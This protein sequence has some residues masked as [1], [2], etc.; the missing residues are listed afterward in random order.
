[1]QQIER[2]R[3]PRFKVRNPERYT[4]ALI[5]RQEIADVLGGYLLSAIRSGQQEDYDLII[6]IAYSFGLE[7][8]G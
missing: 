5:Q 8:D 7:A 2:R 6:S 4:S 3:L 1:M